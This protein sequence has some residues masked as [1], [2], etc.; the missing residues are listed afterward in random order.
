MN[1][2][3]C[4]TTLTPVILLLLV[5][6]ASGCQKNPLG[7]A[8]VK[9]TVTLD[10]EIVSD[11]IVTFLPVDPDGLTASG[12][13]NEKGEFLLNTAG[14]GDFQGAKPGDYQIT[15]VKREGFYGAIIP[16]TPEQQSGKPT[17]AYVPTPAGA[18]KSDNLL[19]SKYEKRDTSGLTFSVTQGKNTCVLALVNE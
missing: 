13:T 10:G 9:G 8:S 14:G 17:Q 1:C 5:L 16:E 6:G 7:L 3:Y 19:P 18:S 15:V 4:Y 11:A 12:R 2:K